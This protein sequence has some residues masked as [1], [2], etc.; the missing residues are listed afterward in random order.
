MEW[1]RAEYTITTDTA[2]VSLD[3][4]HQ[5]LSRESYWAKG[6]PRE[7]VARSIENAMCFTLLHADRHIGFARVIS[8]CATVA[9]LGDVFILEEYR[10]RGLSKWLLECILSHPDLQGLRRWI[11]GTADAHGLYAR[12]GF[13]PL[14]APERFMEKHNPEA[15]PRPQ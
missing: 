2:R 12:Y 15:Y 1:R 10:K 8:D 6:I 13:T 3:V 9:Y 14:A 5:F 4:V 7:R 11:L